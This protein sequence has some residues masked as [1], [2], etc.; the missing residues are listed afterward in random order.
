MVLETM[1]QRHMDSISLGKIY[2]EKETPSI[3][4]QV[5]QVFC[6]ISNSEM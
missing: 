3:A 2:R 4:G 1:D 6:S 5:F